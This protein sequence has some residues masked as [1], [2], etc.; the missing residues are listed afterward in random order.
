MLE[1]HTI[2]DNDETATGEQSRCVTDIKEAVRDKNRVNIYIDSK[3]FCSLD[4]S[5]VVDLRIKVGRKLSVDELQDLKRASEFG[6][7][8]ARALEYCLSRPHSVKE[9][10][11]YL[12]K[13]TL[14]KRVS[15]KNP[16]TSEYSVRIKK[17][18]DVSLV[19]LVMQRLEAHGHL[20]DE[21]FA[22]AWV[23]NRNQRKGSSL[24]KI[25]MELSAKGV[26]SRIIEH[27]LESS[28]RNDR[29]ELKK[30]IARKA[31]RYDNS[32][33]LIQYLVRQGFNYSDVLD[34]LSDTELSS[35]A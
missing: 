16:K 27:V 34:E 35:G 11:D 30:V 28:N 33:K 9:V 8:Y 29:E 13:K 12:Q 10:Q 15:V 18:Y 21:R 7:L 5:Q 4:I 14:D 17:G 31:K 25:K 3:Y 24:K 22:R 19:P 32:Q 1:T 26:D 6:K 20:D 23:E 2:F